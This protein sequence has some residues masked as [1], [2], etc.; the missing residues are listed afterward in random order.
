VQQ[1]SGTGSGLSSLPKKIK[2]AHDQPKAGE[3]KDNKPIRQMLAYIGNMVG[4]EPIKMAQ[5]MVLLDYIRE[6]LGDYSLSEFRI[7]FTMALKDIIKANTDSYGK[8]SP[9]LLQGVMNAYRT[10]RH[11]NRLVDLIR[12]YRKEGEQYM[13]KVFYYDGIYSW[14]RKNRKFDGM[15]Y[16]KKDIQQRARTLWVQHL[17]NKRAS[18]K[19]M[20]DARRINDVL[21]LIKAGEDVDNEDMAI[22]VHGRK[23]MVTEW[24]KWQI[25]KIDK[26]ED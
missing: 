24:V 20:M 25:E 2:E 11:E 26:D 19:N 9:A 14:M 22:A 18:A 13:D 12:G 10:Y 5:E 16:D 23:L 7:A 15:P 6:N 3:S 8:L 21:K 4:A 17:E 1:T